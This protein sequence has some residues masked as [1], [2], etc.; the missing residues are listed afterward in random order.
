[1]EFTI[2]LDIV[3]IFA[4]ATFV[5][6]LFNR[7]NIPTVLGY[8]LTGM[9][10]GPYFLALV[11][12][13]NNIE[14][15]A[16]IGVI[17]LLFTLGIELSLK[18][19]T[20]NRKIVFL[21]GFLQVSITAG[22][23]YLLSVLYGMEWKSSLFIGFL[24]AI[25]STTLILKVLQERSEVTSNYGQTVLGISIFQ[26]MLLVPLLLLANLLGNPE[27]EQGNEI[28]TLLLKASGII[29]FVYVGNR[30]IFPWILHLIALTKNQELFIMSVM[31]I[32][33]GIALLTYSLGMTLAF[34][35]FLAGLMISDSEYSHNTFGNFIPFKDI[36]VSFFFV[37][38]GMLLD[39]NFV[40]NN[41]W[42][43]TGSVLLV[44][45]LKFVIAS[46]VGFIL[47]HTFRG[48]LIIGF[49][50]A[51]VGEFSF[52]LG[53][54][55]FDYNILSPF[56]Y[57][58]FLAITVITMSIMP[59]LM[60]ISI[61]L[62]NWFLKFPMPDFLIKGIFP[63]KEVT[64]PDYKNHLVII[65]KDLTALKIS[66]MARYYNMQHVSIIFDPVVAREKM[67][68]G[69]TVVYGDA[70]NEPILLKAHV[71]TADVVVISVGDI[72]PAMAIIEKVKKMNPRAFVIVRS[73][74]V[75]NIQQ[76]YNL[77]AD[78]VFPEKFET[79]ID[80]F[81]RVLMKR[82]YPQKKINRMMAEIRT[83]NLGVF[84]EKDMVNQP[85]IIDE[86]PNVNIIALT[87][88]PDSYSDGK[89]LGEVDLRKKTGVTLL[90]IKRG[91]DMIE[92]P[93]LR[94]KFKSGDIA[95]VLGD[96]EQVNLASE[97]FSNEYQ[98]NPLPE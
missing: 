76:F 15:L 92:H 7:L 93:V 60:K 36:F 65:G 22:V 83:M 1:M 34:G 40:G 66:I 78:Q 2:L 63:L 94:T 86:L 55:G 61:P 12:E 42:L 50:L 25:S 77:G 46:G 45:S 38:I 29:G 64:I 51:Q 82:L 48:I 14:V 95:Y 90:A 80:F 9:I 11:G 75:E 47:G 73:R 44:L 5:N 96:P 88:E 71:D 53:K 85:S 58:L 62:A 21:G 41:L 23:F 81:N 3:I 68:A 56:Q 16:D 79:A 10:A 32:C 4:L 13:V 97:L 67:N 30:W 54:A 35:A 37:S 31:L 70:V 26:D 33:L 87:I 72:I 28:F 98:A 8:L 49:A 17:F 43:I 6:L 74:N 89:T 91:D 27:V 18:Q 24:V 84:S 69:D 52:I 57:Q 20:K 19:L 39:L 59:L